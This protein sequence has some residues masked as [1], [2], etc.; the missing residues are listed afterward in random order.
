MNTKVEKKYQDWDKGIL[1]LT[2]E[3][4]VIKR[5]QWFW[6]YVIK[7]KPLFVEIQFFGRAIKYIDHETKE[8]YYTSPIGNFMGLMGEF[9]VSFLNTKQRDAVRSC[10]DGAK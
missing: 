4:G 6:N 8:V 7:R 5:L 3:V 10:I 9:R 2:L 1:R